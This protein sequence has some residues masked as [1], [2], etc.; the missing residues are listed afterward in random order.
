MCGFTGF[1]SYSPKNEGELKVLISKMNDSLRHRG[2]D[3]KGVWVDP[4][5]GLALGHRRLAIQDLT[6]AGHQPMVSNSNRYMMVFNGEIY[7]HLELRNALIDTHWR[8]HSDT[9][10]LLACIDSFGI[11]E[12]LKKLTGMFA[13]AIWDRKL[14]NLVIARDRLGEKPIYYAKH[15]STFM[16]ASEL[17]ALKQHPEFVSE[18]NRDS[19]CLYMRHNCIPAPYSI[20]KDTY[21]LK[22]GTFITIDRN[23]IIVES[24]YWDAEQVI[25]KGSQSSFKGTPSEAVTELDKILSKA[26][27]RQV[28]SDV[29]LGAFLSGG[30]D[31]TSIVALM[32][33]HTSSAVKTFT[34]GFDNEAYNEAKHARV[35]AQHLGTDHTE[36][37]VTPNDAMEVIPDLQSIYDEPFADSSQIPT[38]LVSKL[39][40][41][42]VTVA[43]SGDGG[44]ELFAGYN[45]HQLAKSMWPKVRK[46]PRAVRKICAS[47]IM[48]FSP[49]QLDRLNYLLPP[50]SKMRLLGDK[51]H[52]AAYVLSAKDN[53][54]LYLGL[55]SQWKQPESIVIGG[56]EPKTLI[57]NNNLLDGELTDTEIMMALDM[58]TYMPDDI[59]TKVDR[60]SMAVSLETRVP[61]LDHSV[62]EFAW[63]LPIEIK[64]NNGIPKWPLREMLYKYVPKEI[65]ERP[66]MGFGIPLDEWL[67]GPLKI[68]ASEMLSPLRIQKEGYFNEG[69]VTQAW[70]EHLSGKYNHTQQLWCILMFISWL[71]NE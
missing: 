62:V 47:T 57:S 49:K 66:K 70:N 59:L 45:R 68:W 20:Y 7:N 6:P 35:V 55:V 8:G 28:I 33:A 32:Q 30:I 67:R 26:V 41:Q 24:K 50:K 71:E 27:K 37:Y 51:L 44:D 64:L 56:S 4:I 16:F 40:K 69:L 9:E 29:P 38:Y 17:K 34:M 43:L 54:E 42:H 53:R 23:F 46:L 3:S 18:I 25:N 39:A 5:E 31:S 48:Q 2:P 63:Q 14:N 19:L 61:M 21:K 1:I 15:N 12:T 58:L 36:V 60:A 13:I 10:T 22:P 52:K 11:T 65:I